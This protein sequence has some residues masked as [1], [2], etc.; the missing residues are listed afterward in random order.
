MLEGTAAALPSN[1]VFE[2]TV[3]LSSRKP[4]RAALALKFNTFIFRLEFQ[5]WIAVNVVFK[6]KIPVA[7]STHSRLQSFTVLCTH[8]YERAPEYQ[9]DGQNKCQTGG[10]LKRCKKTTNALKLYEFCNGQKN[11]SVTVCFNEEGAV[12]WNM[13][14]KQSTNNQVHVLSCFERL[15]IK[16]L[17]G[18]RSVHQPGG[19]HY[20]R[21]KL[22]RQMPTKT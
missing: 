13:V 11:E 8:I 6:K 14:W 10:T 17:Y 9:T 16:G 19:E 7:W 21:H 18:H 20:T 1:S 12:W 15:D 3:C 22:T 5:W 4:C 2:R